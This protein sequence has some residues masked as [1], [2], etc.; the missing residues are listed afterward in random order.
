MPIQWSFVTVKI[1][2][3]INS[4]SIKLLLTMKQNNKLTLNFSDNK[5]PYELAAMHGFANLPLFFNPEIP[6]SYHEYLIEIF[7]LFNQS[8]F[9]IKKGKYYS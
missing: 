7:S 2:Q 4:Y 9:E 8:Y 5:K 6:I 1:L 3:Y